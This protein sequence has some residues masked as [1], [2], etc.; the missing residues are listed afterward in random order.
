MRDPIKVT[1][2]Q[3]RNAANGAPAYVESIRDVKE[4]PGAKA[5]RKADKYKQ[6]TLAAV[7]KWKENTGAV[8]LQEWQEAAATKGGE[9]FAPGIEAA[10]SKILA[11]QQQFQPFVDGVKKEL[12]AMPDATPDQREQKMLA[13]VRKMRTFKRTRR[14]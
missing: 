7:D 2:K 3:I 4:A 8:S 13:N 5:V 11:F 12:D 9:R 14:R 6:N 10:R 1:E